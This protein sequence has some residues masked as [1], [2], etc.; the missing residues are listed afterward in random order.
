MEVIIMSKR[1]KNILTFAF[2]I[3]MT[4]MAFPG[5][6]VQA[7]EI[8]PHHF[9]LEN[10]AP[11]PAMTEEF[12]A[13]KQQM[14]EAIQSRQPAAQIT[15]VWIEWIGIYHGR[16][17]VDVRVTGSGWH[18]ANFSGGQA[19]MIHRQ[20]LGT[21]VINNFRYTFDLGV[22]RRGS[23]RFDVTFHS[24]NSPFSSRSDWATWT[25]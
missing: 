21:G 7:A 25:W 5:V 17:E 19:R 8:T 23:F 13:I 3:M 1:L 10:Q 4:F 20:M 22:A 2:A 6:P 24:H 15:S 12:E 18:V 11:R 9:D 14:N 16:F